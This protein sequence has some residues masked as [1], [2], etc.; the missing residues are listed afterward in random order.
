[1]Y[2]NWLKH[3]CWIKHHVDF[4]LEVTK[5]LLFPQKESLAQF[6]FLPWPQLDWQPLLSHV[7]RWAA[8]GRLFSECLAE[9]QGRT[10]GE[11]KN[12]SSI[13]SLGRLETQI[14]REHWFESSRWEENLSYIPC[15]YLQH[16]YM[17][18]KLNV[19]EEYCENPDVAG[20]WSMKSTCCEHVNTF[21]SAWP[22]KAGGC[23]EI[24]I[25]GSQGFI[26]TYPRHNQVKNSFYLNLHKL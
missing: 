6:S 10:W 12:W 24:S 18:W 25:S 17:M 11:I 15:A 4:T 21:S 2:F 13:H 20:M 26:K 23:W 16:S 1:M 14:H 3:I 9:P 5:Q 19:S 8:Q 22:S 7:V